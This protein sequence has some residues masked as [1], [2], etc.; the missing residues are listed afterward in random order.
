M[1]S[2]KYHSRVWLN[3][4]AGSAHIEGSVN[5]WDYAGTENIEGE[6]AIHDC[7]RRVT[8]EFG[9]TDKEDAIRILGKLDTLKR[10]VLAF[11]MAMRREIGRVHGMGGLD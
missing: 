11:D 4:K 3:P 9:V 10:E 7:G 6:L 2:E 1:T 5:Q 8:L